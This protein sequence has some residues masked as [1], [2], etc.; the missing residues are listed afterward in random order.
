MMISIIVAIDENRLIGK[1]NQ[2]PWHLP[3]DLAH[4]KAVTMGKPIVMGRKTY[5][6]IGRPLPGRRNIVIS[7]QN[8]KIPGVEIFSGIEEAL[9]ALKTEKEIMIIGG[10]TIFEQVLP[11]AHQLYLTI[12]HH[13]F[14]GDAYFP[15][16]DKN[17]WKQTSIESHSPDEKNVYS[18][19]FITLNK[20][21][22]ITQN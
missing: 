7:R 8:L 9:Q 10:S 12:I 4:F 21:S 2:L 17:Q 15:A 13:Q 5:E 22:L 18:Y 14:E 20:L 6:S 3:A 19:D 16:W 1:N 11:I